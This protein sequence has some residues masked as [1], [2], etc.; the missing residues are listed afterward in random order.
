MLFGVLNHRHVTPQFGSIMP[1]PL[2]NARTMA[3]T[4]KQA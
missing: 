3:Q 1:V 4:E 2:R